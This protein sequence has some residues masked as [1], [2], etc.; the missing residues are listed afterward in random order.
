[1]GET[2]YQICLMIVE[3]LALQGLLTVAEKDAVIAKLKERFHP[4]VTL[5][6]G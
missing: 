5:L 1:M 2:E 6:T 3:Q 4:P